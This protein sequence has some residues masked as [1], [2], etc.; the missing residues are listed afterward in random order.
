MCLFKCNFEMQ[1]KIFNLVEKGRPVD[2][3]KH[4]VTLMDQRG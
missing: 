2:L 1:K 3:R 4:N